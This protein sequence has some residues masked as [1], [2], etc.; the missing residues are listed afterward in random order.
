MVGAAFPITTHFEM[1]GYFAYQLDTGSG[2][3]KK[4]RAVGA[5]ATFYF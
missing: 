4:T 3:N 1:E 5:V 2:P